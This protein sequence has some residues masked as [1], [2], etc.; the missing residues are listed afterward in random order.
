MGEFEKDR[1]ISTTTN[2][3]SSSTISVMLLKSRC[4]SFPDSENHRENKEWELISRRRQCVYLA[5]LRRVI[6][7]TRKEST[8][9]RGVLRVY[10]PERDTGKFCLSLVD[11]VAGRHGSRI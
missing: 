9:E 2:V 7:E 3:S 8:D 1:P 4:T 5:C 6:L 11:H 10:A